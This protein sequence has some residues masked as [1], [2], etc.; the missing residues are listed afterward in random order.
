VEPELF[1]R[2]HP[3]A[4]MRFAEAIARRLKA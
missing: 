2:A 3:D 4:P 1:L